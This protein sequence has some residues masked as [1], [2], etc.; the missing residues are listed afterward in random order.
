VERA[1]R[2]DTRLAHIDS[3]QTGLK[4]QRLYVVSGYAGSAAPAD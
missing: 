1:Y 2:S 4:G 3:L